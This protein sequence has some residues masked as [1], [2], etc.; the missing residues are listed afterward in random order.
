MTSTNHTITYRFFF[1]DGPTSV[2]EV[3]LDAATGC[4]SS[5]PLR[6][7][8]WTDLEYKKCSHCPLKREEHQECPVAG[9]LAVVVD[10]FQDEQSFESA[11]VEVV[12]PERTYRKEVSMQAGLFSLVGLIMSTSGCPHLD[13]LRPMARYHLPFST[14]KETTIR[15]VSFYLLRQYFL[16]KQGHEPD[17]GL[18]ELQK[19]YDAIGEVN[20]GMAARIRAACEA[21][22]AANAIVILDVFAQVLSDQVAHELSSF[23][24]LFSS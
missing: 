15:A 5:G 2:N 19:L 17:Y 24:T 3:V 16:S 1:P 20:V 22:A 18:A 13:F 6:S 4:H 21:D 11:M 10:A 9:N 7:Y 12:T 8:P 23:E 14:A